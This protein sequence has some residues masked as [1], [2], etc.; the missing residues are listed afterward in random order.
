MTIDRIWITCHFKRSDY[1]RYFQSRPTSA[2]SGFVWQ[3]RSA[4]T[5]GPH[6]TGGCAWA[7]PEAAPGPLG[8]LGQLGGSGFKGICPKY[9]AIDG[10]VFFEDGTRR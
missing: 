2:E 4:W 7:W 3:A 10:G 9:C 6:R 5:Q 8:P 1:N